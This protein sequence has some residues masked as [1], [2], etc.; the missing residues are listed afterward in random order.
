MGSGNSREMVKT[1][2]TSNLTGPWPRQSAGLQGRPSVNRQEIKN[3]NIPG[4]L[5]Q[6]NKNTSKFKEASGALVKAGGFPQ[7]GA[8]WSCHIRLC[9]GDRVDPVVPC[10][11][12]GELCPPPGGNT[13]TRGIRTRVP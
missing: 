10:L 2:G 9:L 6:R 12:V 3:A 8:F 13:I 11:G 5:L 4:S 7:Q 1:Q